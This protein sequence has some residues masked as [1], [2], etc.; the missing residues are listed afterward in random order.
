VVHIS[1][2]ST[3]EAEEGGLQVQDQLGLHMEFQASLR[4]RARPCLKKTHN[5]NNSSNPEDLNILTAFDI[6]NFIV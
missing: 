6:C 4:Y 5:N 2:P 1:K 3:Q